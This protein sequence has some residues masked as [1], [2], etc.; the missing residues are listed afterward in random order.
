MIFRKVILKFLI[1]LILIYKYLL[2]PF[3]INRCR[4]LPSC[5][6]YFVES[7]KAHGIFKGF[8]LGTKNFKM[9]SVKILGGG[10]GL[11]FVPK[12]KEI[13]NG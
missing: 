12:K 13:D 4:Y 2:S 3:F 5:S 11:D 6:E 8:Y 1:A 9:P 7:L 10:S